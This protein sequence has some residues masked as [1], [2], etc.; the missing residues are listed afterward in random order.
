[1]NARGSDVPTCLL[2]GGQ[3]RGPPALWEPWAGIRP[4]A[5]TQL[6]CYPLSSLE[7]AHPEHF[8]HC[9]GELPRPL[10]GPGPPHL[11]E[12]SFLFIFWEVTALDPAPLAVVL[13]T[14]P[15]TLTH[16]RL[17]CKSNPKEY[18]HPAEAR[19]ATAGPVIA[20][21]DQTWLLTVF[22]SGSEA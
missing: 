7:A 5:F 3:R 20:L 2:V 13:G 16:S 21:P 19:D 15:W 9:T 18:T 12:G 1:M 14:L 4:G 8:S 22:S 11:P 10:G 6:R 17:G